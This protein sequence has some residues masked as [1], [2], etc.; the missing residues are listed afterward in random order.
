MRQEKSLTGGF[1]HRARP[2]KFRRV[3]DLPSVVY[4]DAK[5]D[6]A[7]VECQAEVS[8]FGDQALCGFANELQ[9]HQQPFGCAKFA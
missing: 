5:P 9:M 1:V 4:G 2:F 3:V 7:C 8:I 6:Q